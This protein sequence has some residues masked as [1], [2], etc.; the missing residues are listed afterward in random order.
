LARFY[1]ALANE[2]EALAMVD[3]KIRT[4]LIFNT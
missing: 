4:A 3:E 2:E 1:D